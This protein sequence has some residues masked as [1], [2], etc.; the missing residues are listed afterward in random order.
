MAMMGLE[1]MGMP[2]LNI[3]TGE[4]K[5]FLPSQKRRCLLREEVVLNIWPQSL[6]LICVRQSACMR[7]WRHR[8]ENCV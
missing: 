1:L 3:P 4:P 5:W 6:H 7:L 8:L 2:G